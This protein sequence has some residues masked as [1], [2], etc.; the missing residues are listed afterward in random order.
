MSTLTLLDI[1]TI[2][3][4]IHGTPYET[5]RF[6]NNHFCITIFIFMSSLSFQFWKALTPFFR[7]CFSWLQLTTCHI[8]LGVSH[9]GCN[10]LLNMAQ[11]ILHLTLFFFF[12]VLGT[13]HKRITSS[14]AT[15]LLT[16][17]QLKRHFHSQARICG[18]NDVVLNRLTAEMDEML[19]KD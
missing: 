12:L 16:H 15:Y 2:S 17:A 7:L 9:R 4:P 6:L 11:Y 1:K 10:F 3:T 14:Y 13:Y 8:L 19:M 5:C 18:Q